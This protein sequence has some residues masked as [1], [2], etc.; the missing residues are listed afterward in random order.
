[1]VKDIKTFIAVGLSFLMANCAQ[2]KQKLF[3]SANV[4]TIC[5]P[6]NLSYMFQ[7]QGPSYREG[8]DPTVILYH[9]E[10]YAFVSHSGGYFHSTDLIHW[11]LIVPNENFPVGVF[12]PSTVIIND[13][14]YLVASQVRQVVKT[15]DP[16]SGKWEIA[17]PDFKVIYS[18]PAFWLDDDG[19]L[20]YYGGCSNTRPIM[21]YE[22]DPKTFEPLSEGVSLVIAHKN[23]LGWEEKTDYNTPNLK[24]NPH[25]EGAWMNKYAG[26]YYL[27][28]AN[29]GTELK[30]YNDAVY[31]SDKPLG[32]FTLAQHNPFSYKP[33][34]FACGAGHGSTFQDKY[35]NYWHIVTVTISIRH[36]FERR[37]SLFPVF[38]DKDNEMYAYT[39]FGDYPFIVPD[40]KINAPEDI[41][42]GWM[43]LSYKKKV[44]VSSTLPEY[45]TPF[46][47]YGDIWDRTQNNE[48][49]N[50]N[51]EE[52]RTWWSAAT[53]KANEWFTM[54]LG[55]VS[56]VYALQIH[57]ADESAQ[58]FGRS[59]DI[60]YQYTI[61]SSPDGEVW[62]MLVDKSQNRIDAPHDYIQLQQ[63]VK[64]Q[65]FRVK[66]VYVHSGNFSVSD[67]RV[68]G[69]SDI[70][71]PQAVSSFTAERDADPRT[72]K[73][74]WKPVDGATGYNIR[75][76]S[77]KDKLYLN[78]MVYDK[79]ELSIHSLNTEQ[80]Y[81]FTIDAFNEGGI[82]KGSKCVK[83][84]KP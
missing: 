11:D 72:V 62:R 38:F 24:I 20:Y 59:D 77:R 23:Q 36:P 35:G 60:Y 68:F 46:D 58:R 30:S 1:M 83:I 74:T 76:G 13:T 22:L 25:I 73:L 44:E 6:V 14:I 39:G 16:K 82:T 7:P 2:Q 80:A 43:L 55:N 50:I 5:N 45:K 26:K 84:G 47:L 69:K 40:K 65:Y 31:V 79:T 66:N 27:Q 15:A 18:D 56:D 67:F 52:I 57:F 71:T 21:G 33:E 53:G 41:F 8:A 28:Y 3:D 42:P 70:E 17:N 63:P 78:Y 37:L 75:Y 4:Q 54:D 64:A 34:G 81:F 12:A 32:P 48:A 10:Y 19:R 9:D 29:P 51:D 49:T 61:E